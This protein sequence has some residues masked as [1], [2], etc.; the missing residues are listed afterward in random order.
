MI[1]Q[2]W[3]RIINISSVEGKCGKPGVSIYV[4]AKHAINGLTKACAHE[5]G[6]LGITVNALCPGAIETDIMKEEAGARPPSRWA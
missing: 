5:V 4:T 6:T 3:G 1:P 2:Q